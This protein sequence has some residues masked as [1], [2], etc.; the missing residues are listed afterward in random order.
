[1]NNKIISLFFFLFCYYT[2]NGQLVYSQTRPIISDSVFQSLAPTPPMGWNSWN[3]FGCNINEDLIIKMADT[4]ISSGMKEAGYK[5]LVIDDCW[6]IS[7]DRNGNIQAD[8]KRFPHGIKYLADYIHSKGLKLGIY[9]CAG[10]LTCQGRPG[11]RG[12]Q[13]QDARQYAAWGVDYLKYDWC[14]NEEQNAKAAYK[15]MSDALKESGR[16]IVFSICEWGENKP[17]KWGKGIGHL[18]RITPDIRN[19]YQC[20]FDWGGLGIMNIIDADAELYPYAGPGHWNDAEMLE[21]GNGGMNIDENIT[22]FSMW[23]ML[24]SPLMA[25]NDLSN[26]D[27]E[28]KDILTNEEVIAIDQDKKGEQARRFMDM[29][30]KEIWV[31]SLFDGDIAICFLNRSDSPWNL[32][33][34]WKQ[35]VIYFANK[36]NFWKN[37]YNVRD[38]WKHTNIEDTKHNLKRRIPS[39]GVFMIRLT[40]K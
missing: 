34:D 10:S 28:T 29:G 37:N 11:S 15:T 31:K 26:M 17:W 19:V 33:Y 3:K 18:W 35:Q 40:Q 25:G 36:I 6:Q 4:M 22:H 1:M 13:F 7:R 8:P 12:Y 23:C 20:N 2:N 27:K 16:P 39:H 32:D 21:I 5:Y 9:S 30:D 14:N 38:L 24:S